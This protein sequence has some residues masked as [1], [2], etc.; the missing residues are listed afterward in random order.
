ML[1]PIRSV[2]RSRHPRVAADV[3]ASTT[4]RTA[5]RAAPAASKTIERAA[6]TAASSSGATDP[7]TAGHAR[8]A[9]TIRTISVGG[10]I[11]SGQAAR[12][13]A[14]ECPDDCFRDHPNE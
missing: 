14:C 5:P 10:A 8:Q 12:L 3:R 1:D 2:S 6:R 11:D 9:R 7:S 4:T 13:P